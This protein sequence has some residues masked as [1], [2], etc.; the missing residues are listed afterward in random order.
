MSQLKLLDTGFVSN[1]TRVTQTQLSD[2]NRAGYTGSAVTSFTLKNSG[3]SLNAQVNTEQ[4]PVIN[5]LD[6]NSSS[7]VS[8][9]NDPYTISFILKKTIT[10]SG[11]DVNDIFQLKRM[12]RTQ[13][14]KLLYPSSDS[15]TIPT[16]VEAF[17]AVNIGGNFSDGS[18]TDDNGTIS[19]TRPYLLGRVKNMRWGDDSTG[20]FWKV[21][22]TF[23]VSG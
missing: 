10:T 11:F 18:P 6:D 1:A 14:L 16:L 9:I 23:E 7:L 17:G 2:A 13:G 19:A 20:D 21:T 3:S 4:K 5:S 15:D 12:E 22:F 8:V